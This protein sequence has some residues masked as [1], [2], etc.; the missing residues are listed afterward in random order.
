M[1][2]A[3]KI[4]QKI[5]KLPE[6]VQAEVLDFIDFIDLKKGHPTDSEWKD[7][8]LSSAMRDMENES[9]PE[10]TTGDLKEKFQ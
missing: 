9:S 1:T 8:S 5:E 6:S 7:L 2:L 4:L 3:Q 10:Y